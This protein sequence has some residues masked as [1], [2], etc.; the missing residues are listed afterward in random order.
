MCATR[1]RMGARAPQTRR[2]RACLSSVTSWRCGSCRL[3]AG[4][5]YRGLLVQSSGEDDDDG[6][7]QKRVAPSSQD[8]AVSSARQAPNIDAF[9]LADFPP[10]IRPFTL[11]SRARLAWPRP[12]THSNTALS[13]SSPLP[14]TKSTLKSTSSPA[15]LP[16]SR[17]ASRVSPMREKRLQWERRNTERPCVLQEQL[18]TQTKRQVSM[19]ASRD[20]VVGPF[21]RTVDIRRRHLR[22]RLI[23][24]SGR[25][26]SVAVP[27]HCLH[28][29]VMS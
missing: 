4:S 27:N 20:P 13:M 7:Q 17:A 19:L 8:G 21:A 10:T 5:R 2:A 22:P 26:V 1:S 24:R 11:Q 28:G 15:T 12:I 9:R 6:D 29:V 18:I 25:E 14:G 16:T 23:E 3:G